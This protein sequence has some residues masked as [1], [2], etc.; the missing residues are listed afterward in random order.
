VDEFEQTKSRMISMYKQAINEPQMLAGNELSRS[1]SQYGKGDVRYV[2]TPEEA[3]EQIEAVTLEDIQK[4]YANQLSAAAG[5]IAVVGEFEQAEVL[6]ALAEAFKDWNSDVEYRSIE[7][8]ANAEASGKKQTIK[9]PDKANAVFSAGLSFSLNDA[10]ADAEAL[11]LGNF[12]FGG[13]TLSSRIGDRIR[14]KEGLS[15][16]ATSSVSIPSKGN[17][18]RFSI[19]AITNPLNMDAVETAAMEELTRFL[20]EGP[21]EQEV[22]NAKT[23]WLE[24][25]KVSRSN[26]GSIA[27]QMASNLHLDRTFEFV[28]ER[29]ERVAQLTAAD[30]LAAFKK[31]IDPS[32]LV[33]VRAGDFKQ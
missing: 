26:D 30:I 33:I 20:A 2:P 16:G 27:G 32:K 15:Y 9:T 1:L 12:I 24:N 3:I 23:A 25:Q 4:I 29:E 18:A 28:R 13:S 19:N 21:T 14:Q 5:E 7:R 10:D 8:E 17:D 22:E 6:S 31:H 11:V